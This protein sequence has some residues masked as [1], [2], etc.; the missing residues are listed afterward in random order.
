MYVHQINQNYFFKDLKKKVQSKKSLKYE[1]Y[2]SYILGST[3]TG[4]FLLVY[5]TL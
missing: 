4:F 1:Y 5:T 2:L 3:N